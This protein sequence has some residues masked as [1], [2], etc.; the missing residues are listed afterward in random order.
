MRSRPGV[1]LGVLAVLAAVVSGCG[2]P[3]AAQGDSLVLADAHELGGYNPIAGYGAA[4]EAKMYEGL[5]RP[6]GGAGLTGFEPALAGAAPTADPSATVWTVGLRP[7]VRFSDGTEFDAEDVVATYRAILDPVSASQA[8]SSF[9][10]IDR[11]EA[12]DPATVRFTLRYPYAAFPTKLLIGIVPA[13]AVATPGPAAESRLNTEPVG[14]GPY[15]LTG[16]TPDRAVLEANETYWGPRPQVRKL[17]LLYVPDDNTRAQRMAAGELDG[18]TLPPLLAQTFQGKYPV[19]SNTSADWRGVSLPEGDPV[20]GDPAVRRA[21]NHAVDRQAIIDSVLGG[22]GRAAYTPFPEEYG[23]SYNPNAVFAF[24]RGLAA[25]ILEAAGWVAG[26]DG[27]RHRDG[28]RAA[29]TVMYNSTDTLRRDLAQAFASDA[30][31]VGIEVDLAALS[32]DRIEPRVEGDGILL[33]GGDEPYDPDT[34]GYKTLHSSYLKP[35]VGSPYDNASRHADPDFDRLLDTARRSIDPGQRAA[36]YRELQTAFVAEPSYVFLVFLDH[37]YVAKD[38]GWTMSGPVLEPHAHG[39]T[40]GPW[41]SL[42]T[43]TRRR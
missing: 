4:G 7:G 28:R 41:W 18:T 23:V 33:G 20:A 43:W 16:L 26:G 38:S 31:R 5:L 2:T 6:K 3:G 25:S 35:G 9:E 1:V 21:L 8:R 11:I 42:Q 13:E 19:S 14:T 29:F 37:V 34:Q 15:R 22:H 39:V 10:M 32:W 24:D 12:V 40:W 30:R 17:T 27:V 36:A